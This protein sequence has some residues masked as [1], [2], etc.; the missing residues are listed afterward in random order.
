MWRGDV[1]HA[2]PNVLAFRFPD[3]TPLGTH[4]HTNLPDPPVAPDKLDLLPTGLAV[5][6]GQFCP[7]NYRL[8]GWLLIQIYFIYFIGG[9]FAAENL[10]HLSFKLT[11]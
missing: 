10:F 6:S 2:C 9:F 5:G 8:V 7:I 11:A 1:I 4:S 3:T